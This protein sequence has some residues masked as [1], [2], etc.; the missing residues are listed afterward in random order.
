MVEADG[1]LPALPAAVEVAA[2]RIASE[3][4]TNAVRHAGAA[5][6]EVRLIGG[7][8]LTV[9]IEDD[10]AGLMPDR[11]AGVGIAS[12]H[13]RAAELGGDC[14]IEARFG[15]GTRVIARLPLAARGAG[16]GI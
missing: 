9:I 11:S 4:M 13:E 6:C 14:R 8:D 1:E 15:G 3:A 7:P 10:G 16:T 12:M 5:R 2:Y